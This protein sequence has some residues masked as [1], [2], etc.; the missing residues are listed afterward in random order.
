MTAL[1]L[2]ITFG[3]ATSELRGFMHRSFPPTAA[4]AAVLE[5]ELLRSSPGYGFP[6]SRNEV[7][8][9]GLEPT[10]PCLQ[11]RC[12]TNCAT[13]PYETEM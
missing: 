10:T 7:E 5:A 6:L 2:V 13:S 8:T 1:N 9:M 12:A 4:C 11:S 3:D